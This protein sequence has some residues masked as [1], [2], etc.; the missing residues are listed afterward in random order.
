MAGVTGVE[1][2]DFDLELV[3]GPDGY[4]ARVLASPT[5]EAETVFQ[6]P[7]SA[8]SLENFILKVGR[9]RSG[10]RRIG[11]PQQEA[12]RTF[13]TKLYDAVFAGEVGTCFRRSLD[14]ADR[15][16][17][18]L[19]VRLRL[20]D[21]PDLA[22]VPWE[23][24]YAE[25]LGRFL[26]LSA[27][28][29]IVR[30]MDLPERVDPLGVATPLR[31]LLVVSSPSDLAEL[32]TAKEVANV[33]GALGELT[34]RGL[35]ELTVLESATL[36]DLRRA[37]RT[38][39]FHVLHFIG[40]GGF[41]EQSDDGVL[42]FQSDTGTRHLVSGHD[43]GTLLHDHS[44]LRLAVL[45]AC[46]GARASA[47][48]PFAGVA[49]SLVRQ[50][51]PAVVAMQFEI[52][53]EAAIAFSKELYMAVLDGYSIDGALA[54]A[55]KAIF[56]GDNDIEW[57]TPVLY[58][59]ARDGRVF[60]IQPRAP[61]T[62]KEADG[63]QP[64]PLETPDS[65][66]RP[67]TV[68]EET[69]SV[70]LEDQ[71][72]PQPQPQD[73]T[74]GEDGET[75]DS[76][77]RLQTVAEEP[78][79]GEGEHRPEA[80]SGRR[81]GGGADATEVIDRI[82]GREDDPEGRRR[83]RNRLLMGV[84]GGL[85]AI[86]LVA[87][88]LSGGGETPEQPGFPT[89]LTTEPGATTA[90]TTEPGGLPPIEFDILATQGS[91]TVDGAVDDWP[92]GAAFE[93]SFV[94]AGQEGGPVAQW[95]LRWDQQALYLLAIT[96]DTDLVQPWE[97]NP[98]QLWRGDSVS[99]ELGVSTAAVQSSGGPRAGDAHYLFGPTL[100]GRV[101]SAVNPSNGTTFVSGGP[102]GRIL[103]AAGFFDTGYLIEI[104]IPWQVV[105]VAPEPN[106]DLAINLNISDG[107]G[108]GDLRTMRSTNPARTPGNQTDP[109]LW[110]VLVLG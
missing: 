32:D 43:L 99:F 2:F 81:G 96:N 20:T 53:D 25:G 54:E 16:G 77:R 42:A 38:G 102:D 11:S 37:L 62:A 98:A 66:R 46:E 87:A 78:V 47:G 40:H 23:Y 94:V 90:A 79:A 27:Q 29:P 58:M 30:Y 51:I 56:T 5:G 18:G 63:E 59:R 31:V 19:R 8:D 45:N 44:S 69:D 73:D 15:N 39:R 3:G 34:S 24:L 101:I 9:A 55:R 100:D 67:Q 75:P 82:Y 84:G 22:P 110:Q 7:F 65:G 85:V 74:A 104:A 68:A 10:I 91:V 41:D 105:G 52:T 6:L 95:W 106:L 50:R 103:A 76:G 97:N 93:S 48:D 92:T 36:A 61:K 26:V 49:Q 88:V 109:N 86:V 60:E 12:A 17:R 35:V 71:A 33:A 4:A 57:G 21:A 83:R 80:E 28:T 64:E 1:Y 107:D 89:T 70:A 108:A 72:Q 14:E 13:G